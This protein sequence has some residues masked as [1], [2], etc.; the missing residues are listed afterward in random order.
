MMNNKIIYTLRWSIEGCLCEMRI[1]DLYVARTAGSSITAINNLL[2]SSGKHLLSCYLFR[3]IEDSGIIN[4][5]AYKPITDITSDDINI[6]LEISSIT[7]DTEKGGF[8]EYKTVL[9]TSINKDN[10]QT[11]FV[12]NAEIPYSIGIAVN[13]IN[14]MGMK[15][16]EMYVLGIYDRI[17]R[18][19]KVKDSTAILNLLEL[20]ER[21]LSISQYWE[22]DEEIRKE[23][24][25]DFEDLLCSG[26]ILQPPSTDDVLAYYGNGRLVR[27][28]R[29]DGTPSLSLL[30]GNND[31]YV[32]DWYFYLPAG[33]SEMSIL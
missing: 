27:Y 14:I 19:L 9:N 10:V 24:L 5:P 33:S 26:C 13:A 2:S 23:R 6:K 17:N 31:R 28:I 4:N 16:T 30:G 18:M 22:I 21:N 32:L 12:F 11:E 8:T 29:P 1:D 20:H 3:N 15:N 7:I 25:R